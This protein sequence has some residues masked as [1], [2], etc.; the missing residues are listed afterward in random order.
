MSIKA[1]WYGDNLKGNISLSNG[2]KAM[3]KQPTA[4][5]GKV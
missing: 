3:I 2:E 1:F 5:F 4:N